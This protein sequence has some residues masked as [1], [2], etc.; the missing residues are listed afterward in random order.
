MVKSALQLCSMALNPQAP[1]PT[2]TMVKLD[3]G[4]LTA[5][6]GT[7]CVRVPMSVEVGACFNPEAAANFFRKDRKT[8]AYTLHKGKLVIQDGKEKISLPY[9]PPDE[10]PTIDVLADPQKAKLDRSHLKLCIDVV[11]PSHSKL[12]CQGIQF[13]YGMMEATN[14]R[15]IVSAETDLDEDIEFNL[16]VDAAK[17]LLR[18][19]TD[20]GGLACDGNSVKFYF[21]DGSSLTSRLICEELME[22]APYYGGKW[23]P[24]NLKKSV[25]DDLLTIDCDTVI[26]FNGNTT[27]IKELSEGV[28]EGTCSKDVDVKM[29]KK[30]LDVLLRISPDI[31]LS[32][33]VSRLQAFADRCRGISVTSR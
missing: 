11:D 4:Y 17:A 26:F 6:G 2:A 1:T 22:T 16:P 9:L 19:K 28:L 20:V 5:F 7:F 29:L 8:V 14:G 15:I 24:L 3:D 12:A 18:F 13:R 10:M 30:N 23:T 21:S 31:A 25:V 33:D 27:Y 32:E